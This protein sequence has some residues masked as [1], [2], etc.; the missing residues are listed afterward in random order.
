MELNGAR[1]FLTGAL[2]QLHLLRANLN[3]TA[4]TAAAA[5]TSLNSQ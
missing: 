2:S 1:P 3:T 4:A 5:A